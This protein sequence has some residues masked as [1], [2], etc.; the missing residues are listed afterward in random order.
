MLD[1]TQTTPQA[2][3]VLLHLGA[4]KTASTHFYRLVRLNRFHNQDLSFALPR[5]R[6][7][8][9]VVT[10]RIR[11]GGFRM[12]GPPPGQGACA[13]ADGHR[14]V[15]ISDENIIGT[16]LSV[17][18]DGMLYP[19]AQKRVRRALHLIGAKEAEL[20]MAVRQPADF[21]VS[22]WCEA[23][24]SWGYLDFRA[25]VGPDPFN[26]LRWTR[27]CRRLLRARPGI[28][29]TVW[30]YED[31]GDV[32][33]NVLSH[34]FPPL[35]TGPRQLF[36]DNAIVRPGLSARA[37]EEIRQFSMTHDETPEPGR[38]DDIM[39]AFP[40]SDLWPAPDPWTAEERK[41]LTRQYRRDL[42]LL[43]DV[44]GVRFVA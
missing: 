39:E 36:D 42:K 1:S 35:E 12:A 31:Y 10:R 27:L 23:L 8:R 6:D 38:I 4:H 34:L 15:M 37:G 28:S 14:V 13:L 16:C 7:V 11:P 33:S 30:S 29:M 5:K 26:A 24:R 44:E 20:L 21:A 9:D 2:E 17:I 3:R 25:F 18:D 40:K 22:I 19:L 32:R 43:K 41:L